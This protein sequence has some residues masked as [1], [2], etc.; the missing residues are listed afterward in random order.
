MCFFSTSQG[1][2]FKGLPHWPDLLPLAASWRADHATCC[3]NRQV[4]DEAGPEDISRIMRN[5]E[6]DPRI[7]QVR[8]EQEPQYPDQMPMNQPKE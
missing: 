8:Q 1:P 4:H 3:P 2:G 7:S 5:T 6:L